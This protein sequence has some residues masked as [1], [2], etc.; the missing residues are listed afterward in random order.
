MVNIA[1]FHLS[2][3]GRS[4]A[5]C[6][7]R[8][9]PVALR[10]D[11]YHGQKDERSKQTEKERMMRTLTTFITTLVLALTIS[12]TAAAET[13]TIVGTGSGA[14]ILKSVG[15]AYTVANPAITV[16]VPKSIGSGG[17]IKAVGNNEY[18]LGRVARK[19]KDKEAPYGLSYLPYANIPVVFF[20]NQSTGVKALTASQILDIYSGKIENWKE[21]GGKNGKVKVVRRE[22]G[23]SSL[24]VLQE[25]FPGFKD[26]A[27]SSKS[28]TTYSDPETSQLVENTAGTIAFGS[29]SNTMSLQNV[30]VVS[31]D[32]TGPTDSGYG[33]VGELAL[34]FKEQNRTGTV[35]D[36]IAFLKSEAAGEAIRKAGGMP[37]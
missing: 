22:E 13:I 4:K 25:T 34:V 5:S 24:S 33:I 17:G 8:I 21:V 26:I 3:T 23:D 2:G 32:G 1:R 12:M 10:D 31:I 15:D 20:V 35:A 7:L 28:K 27:I 29:F 16:E 37:F 30:N 6:R 9:T 19:I 18:V 14:S 36:F 11:L